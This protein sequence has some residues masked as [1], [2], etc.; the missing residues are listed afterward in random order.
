MFAHADITKQPVLRHLQKS[1]SRNADSCQ[2]RVSKFVTL[3][4]FEFMKK[5]YQMKNNQSGF[6][7]IEMLLVVV[8]IGVPY[9]S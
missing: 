9:F 7:L 6:S 1:V 5:N 2:K 4:D 3:L 8:I